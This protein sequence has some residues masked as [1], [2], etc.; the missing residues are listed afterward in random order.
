MLYHYYARRPTVGEVILRGAVTGATIAI[1][2]GAMGWVFLEGLD[3]EAARQDAVREYNCQ[4]YGEAINKHY[5]R[6][7]C[8]PT[9]RG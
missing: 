9:V 6:E 2:L 1:V 8:P 5:G 3:R 4:H 7:V